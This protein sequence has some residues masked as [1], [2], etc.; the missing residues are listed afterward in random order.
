M[1]F[2]QETGLLLGENNT[3]QE[4]ETV[5][6]DYKTIDGFPVPGRTTDIR[7]I[8]VGREMKQSTKS[9]LVEF[10]LFDNLDPKLFQEP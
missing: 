9:E 4:Y 1:Y 3:L 8:G 10:K 7:T 5:Y 6:G 2:D